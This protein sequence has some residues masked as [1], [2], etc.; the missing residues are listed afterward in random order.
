MYIY[1]YRERERDRQRELK[2]RPSR[3]RTAT[4]GSRGKDRT[5]ELNTSE[6][7]EDFQWHFPTTFH[8]SVV[9]VK[10]LSLPQSTFHWNA[11]TDFQCHF[12]H[13][14]TFETSG[15]Q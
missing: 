4:G 8:V 15:A 6:T 5:P 14:F 2:S 10:G 11:P 12:Q 7:I 13:N 9:C 1:I 3:V